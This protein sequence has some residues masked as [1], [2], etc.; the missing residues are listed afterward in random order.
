ME[1]SSWG[2]SSNSTGAIAIATFDYRKID[3]GVN[4]YF[5]KHTQVTVNAK[6]P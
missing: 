3:G 4:P 2:K 6:C 5:Q 1:V